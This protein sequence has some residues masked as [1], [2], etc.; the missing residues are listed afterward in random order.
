MFLDEYDNRRSAFEDFKKVAA[1]EEA[2]GCE[3]LAYHRLVP[4]F[5]SAPEEETKGYLTLIN[6]WSRHGHREW[7]IEAGQELYDWAV[8]HGYPPPR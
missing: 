2:N 3:T 8:D 1:Q 6:F 5:S 4:H 7:L